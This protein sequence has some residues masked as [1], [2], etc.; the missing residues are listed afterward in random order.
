MKEM[1]R[2]RNQRHETLVMFQQMRA[3]PSAHHPPAT[4]SVLFVP[5]PF[6]RHRPC[7]PL[8]SLEDERDEAL[9][10]VKRLQAAVGERD[11]AL[12]AAQVRGGD[13]G[14]GRG[15]ARAGAVQ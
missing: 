1:S 7:P 9:A 15:D 3:S 2:C 4:S 8:Q 13:R 10:L 14:R 11:E 6:P 5:P 12:Q